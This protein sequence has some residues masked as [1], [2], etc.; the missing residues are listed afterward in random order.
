M[1]LQA[2]FTITKGYNINFYMYK[3]IFIT[4]LWAFGNKNKGNYT[5]FHY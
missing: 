2:Q 5:N 1:L 4:N 3:T